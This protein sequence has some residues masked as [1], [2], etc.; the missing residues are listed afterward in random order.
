MTEAVVETLAVWGPAAIAATAF[1]LAAEPAVMEVVTQLRNMNTASAATGQSFAS[2]A[3]EGQSVTDAV[4]PT[5]L[6]AFGV[7]L[8]TIQSS[9]GTLAPVLSKLGGAFDQLAAKASVALSSNSGGTFFQQASDDL[10]KL[11]D[12]FTAVGSII[13]TLAKAVPGYAEVLLNFG[14][15]GLHAGAD[16][17][18]GIEPVLAVF[19]KL[20]G[21]ILYGG[22]AGTAG[23]KIF[24]GLVSGATSA[25]G[26]VA[27]LSAKLLG[28]ESSITVGAG[29]AVV[30]LEDM[31]TGPVLGVG[32]LVGALAAVVLYMKASKTAAD[33]FNDSLEKTVQNAPVAAL[34]QALSSALAQANQKVAASQDQLATATA[35]LNGTGQAALAT[36]TARLGQIR[37]EQRALAGDTQAQQ[38][39]ASGQQQLSQ[40]AKNLNLNLG[41][42]AGTFGTNI[43]GALALASGAQVTSNQLLGQGA[44]N[45]ATLQAQVAGYVAELRVMTPGVGALNQA[46]NVLTVT[47]AQ[48]VTDAQKVAQ[49]YSQWI[50]IVTGGD[51]AFAGFEES[52][53]T[54]SDEMA[55]GSAAGV[56]LTTTSGKLTE[57]QALLGT[58]LNGTS[59][60]ALAA[61]QAFDSQIS[62]ATT[63]YG[64]LQTLAAASGN[65]AQAQSELGKSGKD[66]VAQMLP[67]AAGSKEATAEVFALAQI[68]G[69]TGVDSFTALSKW[70][71]NTKGAE[72][73]LN[74]EQAKLT[75]S[76][77]SLTQA[78][79]DLS[80]AMQNDVTQGEAAA[81][82][83]ATGLTGIQGQLATAVEN[84]NGKVT[85]A[86]QNL[87][88][89]YYQALIKSGASATTAKGDVDAFLQ[90]LGATQGVVA[91]VNQRWPS[92]PRR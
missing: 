10:L 56:K 14:D 25:A 32:L 43:P 77:A 35:N 36:G 38:Q 16:I 55:Q 7:G 62:S 17:V 39:Y 73:D 27:N 48:Q 44:D 18:A 69:F 33:D 23:A 1:G 41:A 28:D 85:T 58:S 89:Q 53:S 3:T 37:D 12:S 79:K 29:K 21:A 76:T 34:P 75:E 46:L 86:A 42:L 40:Q 78:A 63:L 5:V 11:V 20:H 6:E 54:L 30:A 81:I 51:S 64:N 47:Q 24:S 65:T 72:S 80:A 67:L 50:G 13:G 92:S 68:A 66:L 91:Q 2:L 90:E 8:N 19:L 49:A 26:A 4:R 71:G 70:V 88:G 22:L 45:W 31:G 9:S 15:A 57:Q 61:R 60:S 84:A 87:A 83:K 74:T 82:T 52:L 59:T